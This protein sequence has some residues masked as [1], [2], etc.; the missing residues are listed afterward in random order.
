MLTLQRIEDTRAWSRDRRAGGE[1]VALV[2]TMGYLHEGHLSL[3]QKARR[4]ADRVIVSIFVNPTQ[5]GPHEDFDR[6]PRDTERDARLCEE[7]GADALFLPETSEMYPQGYATYVNVE[8]PLTETLCGASRPGHFRGVATVVTKLFT[9]CE[10]DV[11]VFGQKDAQ[12]VAVIRRFT[13]DLNLPVR[14]LV[15]PIVREKDGLAMSSRNV[16]LSDEERRQA[17]SLSASLR[18][19]QDLFAGGERK[20]EFLLGAVTRTIS[21]EPL[22][23]LEYARLVDMSSLE[24]I[25]TIEKP[26][27]LALAVHFGGT[28]LI[29]NTILPPQTGD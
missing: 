18:L 28:R 16:Y 22:A 26:A 8:G 1:S 7:A 27:L 17:L 9:I 13:A 12:Q 5:F 29:D 19:A 2:P 4:N 24:P 23:S 11:A 14:I 6:Y 20:S 25:T 3:I 21:T 15:A 10:P